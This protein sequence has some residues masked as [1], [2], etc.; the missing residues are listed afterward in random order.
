MSWKTIHQSDGSLR[1]KPT[2]KPQLISWFATFRCIRCCFNRFFFC[3]STAT[4]LWSV[5]DP[6]QTPAMSGVAG[7][8][9]WRL[10]PCGGSTWQGLQAVESVPG[11]NWA[12]KMLDFN[13]VGGDWNMVI[14]MGYFYGMW[15]NMDV[16]GDII[17]LVS[18]EFKLYWLVVWN[19]IF[20]YVGTNHPNWRSHI[21]QRGGSTTNQ[22]RLITGI[23]PYVT[24][25]IIRMVVSGRVWSPRAIVPRVSCWNLWEVTYRGVRVVH[26]GPKKERLTSSTTTD[27]WWAKKVK[28][29]AVTEDPCKSI[30]QAS[31]PQHIFP[32]Y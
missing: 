18:Y 9:N 32:E 26:K 13:L 27:H 29:G 30:W 25:P 21:F 5:L 8:F 14:L 22:L 17:P 24:S 6:P 4:F 31:Y 10:G 7:A 15:C 3:E 2:S 23:P 19:F 20:P 12:V 1:K 16:Y 11:Y 28:R